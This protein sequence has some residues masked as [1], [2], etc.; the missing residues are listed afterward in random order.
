MKSPQD[1]LDARRPVWI[2]LSSMFLD[3]DVSLTR[4]SRAKALAASPYSP[5]ELEQILIEEVYPV[6]WFNLNAAEGERIGFD[7]DWLD[8]MILH[9]NSPSEASNRLRELARFAVPDSTE[10]QATKAA[11]VSIRRSGTHSAT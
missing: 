3:A 9:G 7:P 1:D 11:L 2:A 5:Q 4:E 10:W 8:T 6:C